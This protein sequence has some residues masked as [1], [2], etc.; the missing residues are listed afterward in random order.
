MRYLLAVL[1][2]GIV[3]ALIAFPVRVGVEALF[4][5]SSPPPPPTGFTPIGGDEGFEPPT[6][7]AEQIARAEEILAKDPRAQELLGAAD[8]TIQ[9]IP[10]SDS[11]AGSAEPVGAAFHISFSESIPVEGL[12]R[13]R[14]IPHPGDPPELRELE[15]GDAVTYHLPACAAPNGVDTVSA[16]A[17][18]RRGE[19]TALFPVAGPEGIRRCEE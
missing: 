11:D 17:D 14:H 10:V 12:W 15:A 18:F 6:L 5:S 9:I 13:D 16:I 7:T 8:H 4:G 19:L 2:A 1:L 3:I